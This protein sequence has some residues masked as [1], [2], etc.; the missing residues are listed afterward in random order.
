VKWAWA[1]AMF[2]AGALIPAGAALAWLRRR[3]GGDEIPLGWLLR[4]AGAGAV[5]AVA[6]ILAAGS[7]LRLLGQTPGTNTGF[8]DD[9][10]LLLAVLIVAPMHEAAKVAATWP[11]YLRHKRPSV[12]AV[13]LLA[14]TAAA[15]FAVGEAATILTLSPAPSLRRLVRLWLELPAQLGFAA[16]WGYAVGRAPRLDRPVRRFVFAFLSAVLLHGVFRHLVWMPGVI[17]LVGAT[18]LLLGLLLFSLLTLRELEGGEEAPGSFGAGAPS[19]QSVRDVFSQRSAKRVSIPWVFL[20]AFVVQGTIFTLLAASVVLAHRQG[21]IF[22]T[23][24][25]PETAGLAP[26]V[27][28]G[29]P[30]LVGFPVAGWLLARARRKE[31]ALEAGLSAALALL[32]ATTLLGFL[33]PSAVAFTLAAAPVAVAL[34]CLGAWSGGQRA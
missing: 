22:A 2:L 34:A 33:A 26:M 28:L 17:G 12:F 19:L 30:I 27:A 31:S 14:M 5:L 21:V 32:T 8:G 25:D 18:P 7:V 24:E 3:R 9:T 20:G 23:L 1:W 10:S 11:G 13:V 16:L 29:G 15:G 4:T 6:V